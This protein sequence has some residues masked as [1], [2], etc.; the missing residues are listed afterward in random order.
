D[1]DRLVIETGAHHP[2]G[3]IEGVLRIGDGA[4]LSVSAAPGA[5]APAAN[6]SAPSGDWISA[7]LVA[8]GGAILGGLI[9]N[10]M[11]CVFP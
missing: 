7:T 6:E 10:I 1:G 4:G 9:L 3:A 5:V 11:P 2:K 8:L